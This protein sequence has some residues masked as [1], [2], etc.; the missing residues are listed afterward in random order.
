MAVSKEFKEKK[1][2]LDLKHKYDL[3]CH[4]WRIQELEYSR[5]NNRLF[6]ERELE[7]GRIKSAEIRKMQMRKQDPYRN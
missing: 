5:E 1:L 7:R 6:H 3:A 2:I 4:E